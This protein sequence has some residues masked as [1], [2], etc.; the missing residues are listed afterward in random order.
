M[1]Y[2][3]NFENGQCAVVRDSQTIRVYETIPTY[4]SNI[5]YTDYYIQSNYLP[6]YGQQNFSNYST[7]PTCLSNSEITTN[8][9]YRNDYADILIIFLI[10]AF[11]V[12]YFPTK[13]FMSFF[14]RS[15]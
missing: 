7:L 13:I 4:N 10:I 1:V 14:R 11:V 8:V 9:E 5:N 2:V 12:L 15:F 3:P 6:N